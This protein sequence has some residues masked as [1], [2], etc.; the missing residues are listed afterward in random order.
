MA[1]VRPLAPEEESTELPPRLRGLLARG[2]RVVHAQRDHPAFLALPMAA[3]FGG[4]VLAVA[5]SSHTT[6]A[7]AR[8]VWPA[9]LLLFGWTVYKFWEWSRRWFIVTDKRILRAEG[10]LRGRVSQLM[11]AL[12]R[13]ITIEQNIFGELLGFGSFTVE[14]AKDEH[15]MRHVH[16]LSRPDKLYRAISATVQGAGGGGGPVVAP[17][18]GGEGEGG[19]VVVD[20]STRNPTQRIEVVERPRRARARMGQ[21]ASR[22]LERLAPA[23]R[24]PE[25]TRRYAGQNNNDGII[26][27]MRPEAHEADKAVQDF[28]Y[29]DSDAPARRPVR[30]LGLIKNPGLFRRRS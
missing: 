13:D 16:W 12:G 22:A 3:L 25:P 5:A 23:P 21:V 11:I 15:P 10:T 26:S 8:L 4:L 28:G 2:E 24:P 7:G 17:I 29:L 1:A 30:G 18:I 27:S 14:S 9:W 6:E 20:E 19:I